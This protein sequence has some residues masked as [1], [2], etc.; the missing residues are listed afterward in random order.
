MY[1]AVDVRGGHGT[2]FEV[3]AVPYLLT[4]LLVTAPRLRARRA[5]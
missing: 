5:S 4:A 2:A 1:A 3:F